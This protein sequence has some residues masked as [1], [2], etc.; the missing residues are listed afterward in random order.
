MQA[1]WAPTPALH[2]NN[3][4]ISHGCKENECQEEGS[5]PG[6]EY[7]NVAGHEHD[8]T[9]M[10]RVQ[11]RTA[12]QEEAV[13]IASGIATIADLIIDEDCTRHQQTNMIPLSDF[14]RMVCERYNVS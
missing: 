1:F 12:S 8:S 2:S 11:F 13:A 10:S 9:T 6:G 3:N 14:R 7:D 4:V 5:P